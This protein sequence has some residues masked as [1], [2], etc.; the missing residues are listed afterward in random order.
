ML[1]AVRKVCEHRDP[2]GSV[3]TDKKGRTRPDP[4]LRDFENVPHGKQ[5]DQYLEEEVRP[6]SPDAWVDTDKTVPGYEI[7]ITRLFYRY[8][9]PRPLDEIDADIRD[10]EEEVLELLR[11]VT[12]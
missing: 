8:E 5:I 4:E 9:P 6:W 1:G 7:P 3:T 2:S 10:L 11:E 12:A